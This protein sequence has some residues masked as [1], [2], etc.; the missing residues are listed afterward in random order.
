VIE[1]KNTQPEYTYLFLIQEI[2]D[3]GMVP[4]G[5]CISQDKAQKIIN[6]ASDKNKLV[7]M[8]GIRLLD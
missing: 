6:E 1:Y 4:I 7:A 3:G 8:V 2:K 5:V